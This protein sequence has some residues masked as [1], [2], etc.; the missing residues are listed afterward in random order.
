[1]GRMSE[2]ISEYETVLPIRPDTQL[3]QFVDRLRA[4]RH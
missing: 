4:E 3:Q 1:M 2:A